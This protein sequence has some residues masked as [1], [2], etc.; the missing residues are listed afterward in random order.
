MSVVLKAYVT[1]EVKLHSILI[2][3]LE[4]AISFKPRP[5]YTWE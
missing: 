2:S 4:K 5:L 3:V 1:Q